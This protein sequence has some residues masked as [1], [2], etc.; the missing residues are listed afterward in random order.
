M[1]KALVL[2]VVGLI[3]GGCAS[4]V[5]T[6]ETTEPAESDMIPYNAMNDDCA[7]EEYKASD[8]KVP[9]QYTF[10]AGYRIDETITTRIS[11]QVR[12]ETND[13]LDMSLGSIKVSSR[14]VPFRYNNRFVPVTIN[15]V[16]PHEERTLSLVGS[17]VKA[18][19]KDPWL[20]I[21]GEEL[22]LTL[23]GLRLEGRRLAE[24]T[25]RFIPH[26]PKLAN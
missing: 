18:D 5:R 24:Q 9:V 13:T 26:N 19:K 21:A 22:V 17:P 1:R 4:S 12:N 11:I 6:P 14:N 23:R 8:P 15:A 20:Y 10:S 16:P 25:V 3:L 7:C 2:L